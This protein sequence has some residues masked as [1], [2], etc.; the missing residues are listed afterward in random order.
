VID[1]SGD[2]PL[3]G[4]KEQGLAPEEAMVGGNEHVILE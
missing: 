3:L 1:Y 4:R 2:K